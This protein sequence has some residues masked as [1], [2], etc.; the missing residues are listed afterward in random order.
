MIVTSIVSAMP[1]SGPKSAFRSISTSF[2]KLVF[3]IA[4]ITPLLISA[5]PETYGAL[6]FQNVMAEER[7]WAGL[8]THRIEVGDVKWTYSEGGNPN[9]PTILL[10]HGLGG[11][12][13]NWNR[14]AHHL[15]PYYHVVIPDLP[16]SGDSTI[17]PDYDLQPATMT[18][19]L[20]RFVEARK[21]Q[22]NLNI[23]GHSLGGSIAG[24]YASL[25]FED[26]QSLLLVAPGGVYASAKSPY[27]KDPTRLREL[28]LQKPGDINKVLRVAMH[29]PP[30]VPADFLLEQEKVMIANAPTM[31]KLIER[32]ILLNQSYTPESFAMM[33]RSIEAPTL[34]IWGKNDS[35]IDVGVVPEL[36]SSLKDKRQP[37]ILDNVG[38]TPILEAEQ[39]VVQAYLP[40][41]KQAIA[42]PNK[43][44]PAPSTGGMT[45]K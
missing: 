37:V 36:M 11:S 41:L 7:A 25:Y 13:D 18:E 20:R 24:F 3:S 35:I 17:A 30:F 16:G 40:F 4:L 6:N 33:A 10:I 29:N 34:V 15:T 45:T 8:T 5:I 9:N 39:L 27:L 22:K 1:I 28:I 42:T 43:F 44:T 14:V 31:K 23:A 26:T 32:M 2:C 19:S 12:R 21:I 38:H